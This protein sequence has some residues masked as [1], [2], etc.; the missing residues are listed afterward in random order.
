M[1]KRKE[2]LPTLVFIII[3]AIF[4]TIFWGIPMGVET[5]YQG[6]S[7]WGGLIFGIIINCILVAIGA[8]IYF[9]VKDIGENK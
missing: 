4:I 9:G 6:G 2:K 3:G 7:F 8:I 5:V 1:S